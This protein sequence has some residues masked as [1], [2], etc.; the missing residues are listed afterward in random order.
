MKIKVIGKP[1][2]VDM[3]ANTIKNVLGTPLYESIST[4]TRNGVFVRKTLMFA[5]EPTRGGGLSG[6]EKKR[7]VA[8][9]DAFRILF[10]FTNFLKRGMYKIDGTNC[11]QFEEHLA[12]ACEQILVTLVENEN[13]I[14]Q[15]DEMDMI[16]CLRRN[17]LHALDNDGK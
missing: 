17:W 5:A 16:R 8:V 3:A 12:A 11:K 14:L 15:A 4:Y 9:D 13:V 10:H 7:T 6:Q 2:E 1:D